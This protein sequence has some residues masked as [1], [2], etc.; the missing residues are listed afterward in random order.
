MTKKYIAVGSV[1]HFMPGDEI[2][3]LDAERIQA[4]LASGV[5]EEFK[6]ADVGKSDG[7]VGR[8]AELEKSVHD[9]TASNKLFTDEKVKSDQLNAEL[10]KENETLKAKIAELEKASVEP[11][12]KA[13]KAK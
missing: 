8:L 13:T 4:L 10:V 11:A 12:A 7:D 5:I 2:K 9:L 1:G 3:G 6:E